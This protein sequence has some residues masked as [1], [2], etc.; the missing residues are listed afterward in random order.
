LDEYDAV[1]L[2]SEKENSHDNDC[3]QEHDDHHYDRRNNAHLHV[4]IITHNCCNENTLELKHMQNIKN[5]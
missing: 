3:D 1:K 5:K 4:V 2:P